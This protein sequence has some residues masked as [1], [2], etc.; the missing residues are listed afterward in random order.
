[1]EQQLVRAEASAKEQVSTLQATV[2]SLVDALE[3]ANA[4][5]REKGKAA[6]AASA[7]AEALS[8]EV[9]RLQAKVG[10]LQGGAEDKKAEIKA[11]VAKV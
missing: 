11:L 6:S 8:A 10:Q 2:Q 4:S 3:K 5:L 7:Q 1:M 9:S